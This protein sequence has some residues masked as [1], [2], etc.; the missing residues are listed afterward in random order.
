MGG[1]NALSETF[2]EYRERVLGYLGAREP[3]RVLRATPGRLERLASSAPHQ[4]L[5]VRPAPGK[6]STV[7]ILAHLADAELAFGWRVRSMVATSGV[8]LAWWDEQAWSEKCAY[9]RSDP[10]MSLQMFRALRENTLA[11]L[12]RLAPQ[13]WQQAFGVHEKRGRQTV[14]DFLQMEA[15]H[16][17]NHI[18]QIRRALALAAD[19]RRSASS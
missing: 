6:W 14:S 13:V 10:R 2:D 18:L 9:A 17:L 11:L 1:G 4:D 7:E 5:L 15:A 19:R 3:L 12:K 16:D 8:A